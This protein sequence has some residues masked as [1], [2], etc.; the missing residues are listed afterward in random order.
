MPEKSWYPRSCS[1]CGGKLKDILLEIHTPDRFEH[2]VGIGADKYARRW[3]RCRTCHAAS[4]VYQAQNLAKLEKV[5]S[6][7]YEIDLSGTSIQARYEKIM[8]LPAEQSDNVQ[9]VSRIRAFMSSWFADRSESL[10]VLDIGAGTG[11]FLSRLIDMG[12]LS[13]QRF[14]CT[15][16]ESDPN[17]CDHLRS[18]AKFDVI[19]GMFQSITRKTIFDMCTLNKVLE[20]IDQPVSFLSQLVVLMRPGDGVVYI[21]VPDILTVD[22]RDSTDNILGALHRHLYDP[23]SLSRLIES[24]GLVCLKVER[25]VEPSGKLSVFAFACRTEAMNNIAGVKT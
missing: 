12:A 5:A 19:E 3:V 16:L 17:A 24:V 7:Y 10:S 18:L 13:Q 25:I 4:D 8:N 20:H 15:A 22:Y 9:R 2:A 11:V 6:S 14:F 21:E 23:S 1:L